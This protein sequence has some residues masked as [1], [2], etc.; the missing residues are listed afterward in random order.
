MEFRNHPVN[1]F[2]DLFFALMGSEIF[3]DDPE[4]DFIINSDDEEE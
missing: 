3:G 1:E 4:E 2:V